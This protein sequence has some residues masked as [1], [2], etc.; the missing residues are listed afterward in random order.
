VYYSEQ[1]YGL[2][3]ALG[4]RLLEIDRRSAGP[5]SG[6]VFMD[7]YDL[8]G[9]Y[10]GE[11]KY[12]QAE[13]LAS[14]VVEFR[15]KVFGPDSKQ[16][17]S[18]MEGLFIAY[19]GEKK[20]AQAEA[21]GQQTLEMER[22]VMGPEDPDTL[23]TATML[24]VT[25]RLEGKIRP[26]ESLLIKT[27]ETERRVLGPASPYTVASL[28][29]LA[30]DYAAQGRYSEAEDL[31]R[32]YSQG[33][34]AKPEVDKAFAWFLVSAPDPKKRDSAQ[35]LALARRAL[36]SEPDNPDLLNTLGLAEV[37]NGL[38][39]EATA[40]LEKAAALHGGTDPSDFLFLA[41][42]QHDRGDAAQAARNY[43][44]AVKLAGGV[45]GADADLV[46]LWREIAAGLARP[47][48][49][50]SKKPASKSAGTR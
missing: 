8:I 34:S 22:R 25:Y 50:S 40:T 2:A 21:L 18:P 7:M 42:A 38:W 1:K 36:Q 46:P 37:Q 15:R 11:G 45:A 47:G 4:K 48:P 41:Q 29:E 13:A 5:Q 17:L 23:S 19:K 14:Q 44:R 27:L 10:N 32:Q 33:S 30:K 28:S 43:E 20:Y 31:F 3:E 16:T 49:P 9:I 35:G 24:A 26:S 39:E 12:P 6:D